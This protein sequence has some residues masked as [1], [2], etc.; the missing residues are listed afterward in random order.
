MGEDRDDDEGSD[1]YE[2]LAARVHKL[3][4]MYQSQQLQVNEQGIVLK[5]L[6]KAFDAFV[7]ASATR[8]QLKFASDLT[9]AKIDTVAEKLGLIQRAMYWVIALVMG[10]VF[11]AL[12]NLVL[13]KPGP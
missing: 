3:A 4:D 11:V 7:G 12:L 9:H 6:S 13:R 1:R 10:G 5:A 2:R 8:E